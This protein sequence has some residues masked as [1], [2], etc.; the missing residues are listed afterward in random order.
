[1]KK[2]VKNISKFFSI[3]FALLPL[4]LFSSC[5]VLNPPAKTVDGFYIRHFDCC[6]PKSLKRAFEIFYRENGIVFVRGIS[7]EEI[8]RA[9]QKKGNSGRTGLSIL[10]RNAVCITW[11]S[12]IRSMA[13]D[14]G[15][16]PVSLKDVDKLKE[17]D[18][19]II[20]V[21]GKAL[22]GEFHWICFPYYDVETI[23]KWYGKT[24]NIGP[25][26]LFRAE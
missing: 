9:M 4:F 11:P 5:G 3:S 6:G 21:R 15:F 1:M 10:N 23:K 22:K 16:V 13:K 12:E 20:L 26:Y 19:A 14:Y 25:I 18:I 2:C 17:G 7:S 24:T 8:S